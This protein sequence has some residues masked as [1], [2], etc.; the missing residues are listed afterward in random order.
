MVKKVGKVKAIFNK[1]CK[2]TFSEVS[3]ATVPN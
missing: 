2:S 3:R 1:V